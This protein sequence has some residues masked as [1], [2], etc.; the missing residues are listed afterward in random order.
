MGIYLS[1]FFDR[2][3]NDRNEDAYKPN[4]TSLKIRS[5]LQV[6]LCGFR[7]FK[8]LKP[9]LPSERCDLVGTTVY[10]TFSSL[11]QSSDHNLSLIMTHK[12]SKG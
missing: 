8:L 2:R 12:N 6:A 9:V 5:A 3:S 11:C 10:E 1:T 7:I 4:F